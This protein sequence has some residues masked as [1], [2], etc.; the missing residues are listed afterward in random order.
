MC[1][2]FLRW[3]KLWHDTLS[4]RAWAVQVVALQR[5][6]EEEQEVVDAARNQLYDYRQMVTMVGGDAAVRLLLPGSHTLHSPFWHGSAHFTWPRTLSMR[7]FPRSPP[8]CT[9][10]CKASCGAA[11]TSQQPWVLAWAFQA[12]LA[13]RL[14][15]PAP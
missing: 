4:V 11:R 10:S 9:R 2:C 7:H 3:C 5:R 12:V 8:V 13:H 1:V 15:A 14:Q 6:L